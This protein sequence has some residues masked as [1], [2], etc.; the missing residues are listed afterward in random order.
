MTADKGRTEA[1]SDGIF[2]IA[3]TL[4]ILE[5]KVPERHLAT[6]NH[7]LVRLL[8]ALWPSLL[9]FV[10]S[11]VTILVMWVNHHGFFSLLKQI[12]RRFL[13]ANG[14]LLLIV[15]FLPFPTALVAQHLESPG[16][17]TA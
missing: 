9:A 7:E 2:S 8:V 15:V 10:A 1:F 12:D 14:F 6:S 11:F 16:A 3:I 17:E 13:Y 4:L 5:F